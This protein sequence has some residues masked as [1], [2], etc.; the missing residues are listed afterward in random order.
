MFHHRPFARVLLIAASALGLC[1]AQ[2]ASAFPDDTIDPGAPPSD[3]PD[4][5]G[6]LFN[7]GST[8]IFSVSQG[9]AGFVPSAK[10]DC[11]TCK[12]PVPENDGHVFKL[13]GRVLGQIRGNDGIVIETSR[14]V[15]TMDITISGVKATVLATAE[16]AGGF[17]EQ[18]IRYTAD[19]TGAAP[20]KGVVS[21]TLV[22]DTEAT[23]QPT[24]PV[25]NGTTITLAAQ[26]APNTPGLVIGGA[27][28]TFPAIG[29]S[30]PGFLGES[31]AANVVFQVTETKRMPCSR[32]PS[33][34]TPIIQ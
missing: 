19:L 4:H 24:E 31:V 10:I 18:T 6:D 22:L 23:P 11:T 7:F 8:F 16:K 28:R 3:F 13:T 21:G 20:F 9:A 26:T 14:G 5:S 32:D 12:F 15:Y 2:G 1:F 29:P 17:F 27:S 30:S 33:K 34:C 25:P